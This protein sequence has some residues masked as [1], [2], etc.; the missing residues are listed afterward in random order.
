MWTRS[1]NRVR[2]KSSIL[3]SGFVVS[4]V[5]TT[6]ALSVFVAPALAVRVHPFISE[7]NLP[8][9]E[10]T[11]GG[12]AV[13]QST[14]HVY[15]LKF[16]SSFSSPG[17]IYDFEANGQ[18]NAAHPQLTGAPSNPQGVA[19]DNSGGPHNG[20]IYTAS[21]S[22]GVQQY[23]PSG[24]ATSVQIKVGA[25]PPNG[26]PQGGG[27]PPVVN[28]GEFFSRSIAVDGSGKIYVSEDQNEAINEFSA[29]G[30]FIAQVGAGVV[31][32]V[33]SIAVGPGGNIYLATGLGL[34]EI[35]A[36]G[37]CVNAC[38]PID[39][40]QASGVAV[41]AAGNVLVTATEA[42][43]VISVIKEFDSSGNL[44]S[45]SGAGQLNSGFGIA[46]DEGSGRIYV[47][48]NA[49][50]AHGPEVKPDIKVFGPVLTFPDATTGTAVLAGQSVTL[51]GE[52]GADGGPD[53]T[54]VFQ[55]ADESVFL[56]SGFEEAVE[57][58]CTPAG[59]FTGAGMSAVHAAVPDLN[60]GTTYRY[61]L[62]A[63]STAGS[64]AG[65]VEEFS[66]PGPTVR[67]QTFS[68]SQ[69]NA[70][71]RAKID[72]NGKDTTYH[73]EY[74][75]E[76]QF[77]QSGYAEA[78]E[79]PLAGEAIGSGSVDVEVAQAIAGLIPGAA[80]RFRVLASNE[81]GTARGPDTRFVTYI[82]SNPGL[83][84]ARV[85]EQVS[86][87]DK[88]GANVDGWLNA[89]QAAPDGGGITFFASGGLPGGEGA[90][91]F[92]IYLASRAPGG[93]STQSLS[94]PAA[95]GP[96]GKTLGWSEDLRWAYNGNY[97]PGEPAA[98]YARESATR[99]TT[100]A[101]S[102]LAGT[103]V[104]EF[105][106]ALAGVAGGDDSAVV[107]ED[108]AQLVPGAIAGKPNVYLWDRGAEQVRLGAVLNSGLAPS[109]GA[110]A[111][112]YDW[113]N[114][115][116]IGGA[117][118]KY[119]TYAG[120]A[121]SADASRLFFTAAADKQLYVRI[122][123]LAEQSP[124]GPG[125]DCTDPTKACTLKVSESQAT[126]P[127]PAG[128]QPAAFAEATP[129]GRYVLFMSAGR[130]TDD[131]TAG[132]QLYRY[133][134][135]TRQ[136]IDLSVDPVSE[137]GA[138]VLGVLGMSANGA[139]VYFAANGVLAPGAAPGSCKNGNGDACSIYAWHEG[140]VTLI[141]RVSSQGSSATDSDVAN[142]IPTTNPP[143]A[144]EKAARVDPGGRVL[145]FRS[146]LPL[147][148]YD[149]NRRDELYRAELTPSGRTLECV[150]CNPSGAPAS[151]D[152]SLQAIPEK[153]AA[154]KGQAPT[155]T[156][157]LSL[158]GGRVFFDT[159]EKLVASDTNGVNDV[160]EWE[161]KGNGSCESEE[162]NGGC[163]YLLSGGT[164]SQP[165]YFADASASG[166]DAFLF[167][168]QRLVGQDKDE[169]QDV[170]DARVDGGIAAQS[171]SMVPICL[172]EAACRTARSTSPA[173]QSAGSSTF[174]GPAD[175]KPVKCKRN[176]KRVVRHGKAVCVKSKS[177]KGRHKGQ[178][179]VNHKRKGEK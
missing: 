21:I 146:Q 3:I 47:S 82:P 112:P 38:A 178:K 118:A 50:N 152:A 170:Y 45:S 147:T 56:E 30:E 151:G 90:Q 6:A 163:L 35:D 150:S 44:I 142:W 24:A 61:R 126:V 74:V 129:D 136:L 96:R 132:R 131:A 124:L 165:S 80:Y 55:Y 27:L 120:H 4:L 153:F 106:P 8:G 12:I 49:L 94:P 97:V 63:T 103:H 107:F 159:P 72:P 25:I 51:N 83:P 93:W 101:A 166:D 157:N 115:N 174:S 43:S 105:L 17:A 65:D 109:Q 168:Y 177:G 71:L 77:D 60:G 57:V 119:Y 79:V 137:K 162:Q 98:F 37:N 139:Y 169:L 34:K 172:S 117:D 46:L 85:Y 175:P 23:D 111:G 11:P 161:A 58:P 92:P 59:P 91:G 69:T 26:T 33:D 70:T 41:D 64:T 15:V 81:L 67:S 113:F 31:R 39:P 54:C 114:G 134:T 154:P 66:V 176:F 75:S 145:L 88:N 123:P 164:G 36:S 48:D 135:E 29:T 143:L 2:R 141:A 78:I 110:F 89:V 100:K 179:R 9:G 32:N 144:G 20:Y 121:I 10:G 160:Y 42:P 167:T 148:N 158:G 130:L 22:Q 53:T 1:A 104:G 116:E 128:E 140:A 125:G 28:N 171:P 102:G 87:I 133:D 173:N 127:D 84:D 19:V 149:N 7:F 95:T 52:V 155:L 18:L 99:V 5:A 13:N 122:N 108:Q 14:H 62:L 68:V 138:D 73:F 40:A 16:Q 76:A 156:R 86:P